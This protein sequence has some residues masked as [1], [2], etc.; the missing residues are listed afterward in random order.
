VIALYVSILEKETVSEA[1]DT[2][3]K[4]TFTMNYHAEKYAK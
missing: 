4:T 3:N 1:I 2:S